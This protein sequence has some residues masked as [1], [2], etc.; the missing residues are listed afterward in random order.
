MLFPEQ[1]PILVAFNIL[2]FF[3]IFALLLPVYN[4]KQVSGG[5]FAAFVVCAILFC[6]FSFWGSDWFH[7]Q[8]G[9]WYYK[10]YPHARTHMED[11]YIWLIQVCPHYFVFRFVIW[12]TALVLFHLS[13]KRLQLNTQL[14][15]FLFG[16]LYLPLFAYG[17]FSLAIAM[18]GYGAIL[19]ARPA[20]N[21]KTLS[22][23]L[24]C[25]IIAASIF[26]HKSAIIGVGIIILCFITK[27]L[28]KNS[29]IWM[30]L[31]FIIGVLLVKMII[32]DFLSLDIDGENEFIQKS[33]KYISRENSKS[34]VGIGAIIYMLLERTP[35]YLIAILAY[36]IQRNFY[37]D[38]GIRFISK[39]FIFL[40]LFASLFAF[41]TGAH[42]SIFYYRI[43]RF[44][45][46][47]AAMVLCYAHYYQL[48]PKLTRYTYYMAFTSSL[49][50]LVYSLYLRIVETS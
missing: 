30:A 43:L 16:T 22:L 7:Y 5:R 35:Y 11:V 23:L 4:N 42:T 12:G 48:Y 9:F 29:W 49:Y 13:I 41:D 10:R 47:P 19:I 37:T 46:V 40:I 31:V 8:D 38:K 14:S 20:E 18:M 6:L 2:L 32:S 33:Q 15:W 3:I 44:S 25:S 36:K 24:G 45:I 28:G 21:Q 39:Y 27:D 50:F 26:F 34:A 17:R 1:T